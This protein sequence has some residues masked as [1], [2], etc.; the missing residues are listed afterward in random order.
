MKYHFTNIENGQIKRGY[1]T[2]QIEN[3]VVEVDPADTEAIL[4]AEKHGGE[5]VVKEEVKARAKTPPP[6]QET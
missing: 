5:L 4:L 6:T 2:L 1:T 3:H